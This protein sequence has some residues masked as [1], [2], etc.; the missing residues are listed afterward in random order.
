MSA[1]DSNDGAHEKTPDVSVVSLTSN[2]IRA[3]GGQANYEEKGTVNL[4][5]T[6]ETFIGD[7]PT[8]VKIIKYENGDSAILLKFDVHPY[9]IQFALDETEARELAKLLLNANDEDMGQH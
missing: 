1:N 7:K 6:V 2:N 3:D 9:H 5:A 4:N 8:N